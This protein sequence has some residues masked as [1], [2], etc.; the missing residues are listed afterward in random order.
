MVGESRES[1][2]TRPTTDEPRTC[3]TENP[4]TENLANLANLTNLP[5]LANLPNLC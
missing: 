3:E 5:N 2:R 1:H 4:R